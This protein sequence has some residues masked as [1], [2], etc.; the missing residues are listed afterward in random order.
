MRVPDNANS[1]S[2]DLHIMIL[3]LYATSADMASQMAEPS[4]RGYMD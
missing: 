3:E 4:T 1:K 2:K